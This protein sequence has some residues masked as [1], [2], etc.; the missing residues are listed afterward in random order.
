MP[1]G[2]RAARES[3]PSERTKYFQFGFPTRSKFVHTELKLEI[4]F[5]FSLK[6]NVT[7][8]GFLD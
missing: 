5:F 1:E 8:I 2:T 3:G 6:Y 7:F 4:F